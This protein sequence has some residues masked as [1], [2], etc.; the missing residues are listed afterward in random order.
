MREAGLRVSWCP[1]D[2]G[3]D[4]PAEVVIVLNVFLAALIGGTR[5]KRLAGGPAD[6]L[7]RV[8]LVAA[9]RDVGDA[10]LPRATGAAIDLSLA[11]HTMSNDAAAQCAHCGASLWMAHSKQSKV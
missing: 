6:R 7:D 5:L 11:L 3:H 2:G 8:A 10:V 4:M 1:F 9:I